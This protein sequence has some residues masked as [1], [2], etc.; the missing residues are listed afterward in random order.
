MGYAIWGADPQWSSG[1]FQLR[2]KTATELPVPRSAFAEFKLPPIGTENL[3]Q[4]HVN[5][6]GFCERQFAGDL[7][8]I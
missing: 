1:T 4:P 8:I 7:L 5:E 2:L 6:G 3:Q